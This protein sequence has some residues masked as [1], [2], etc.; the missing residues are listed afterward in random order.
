MKK[1]V[2]G[3]GVLST[4]AL[5]T[6]VSSAFA[7]A[8]ATVIKDSTLKN[9][10]INNETALN[11]TG[12]TTFTGSFTANAP[13]SLQATGPALSNAFAQATITIT[14]DDPQATIDLG[15]V[16][17]KQLKVNGEVKEIKGVDQSLSNK[18]ELGNGIPA[19]DFV[20]PNNQ[21]FDPF[22]QPL[23]L[24]KTQS[25]PPLY[26]NSGR[27]DTSDNVTLSGDNTAPPFY[28]YSKHNLKDYVQITQGQ[29]MM[30][31][32]YNSSTSEYQVIDTQGVSQG[33]LTFETSDPSQISVSQGQ[34]GWVLEPQNTLTDSSDVELT[35]KVYQ[36]GVETDS[37]DIPLEF[38][39]TQPT[40]LEPTFT[41]NQFIEI[42]FSEEVIVNQPM[43]PL[44]KVEYSPTGSFTDQTVL[45]PQTDYTITSLTASKVKIDVG[46]FITVNTDTVK[47]GGAFRIAITNLFDYA[48]NGMNDSDSVTL[49]IESP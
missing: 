10:T 32:I 9:I 48:N 26:I 46:P 15:G 7:V 18:I 23:S 5:Q 19:P 14:L 29:T 28:Q 30:S 42:P 39:E 27:T 41:N 1:K 13:L 21:E 8:P 25:A 38:D 22:L 17:F 36:N 6:I 16:T 44:Y 47:P 49:T 12:N 3:L 2:V 11:V 31:L 37:I 33:S 4:L 45:V 43:P 34:N 24:T 35:V 40:L 20:N